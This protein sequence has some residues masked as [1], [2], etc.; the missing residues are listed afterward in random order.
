MSA[1]TLAP[2]SGMADAIFCGDVIVGP[3]GRNGAPSFFNATASLSS[4][5][6]PGPLR[7][8]F[9]VSHV[10]FRGCCSARG[11]HDLSLA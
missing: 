11:P 7:G 3:N 4:P 9:K 5:G 8:T 6:S 1:S 2:V 10:F